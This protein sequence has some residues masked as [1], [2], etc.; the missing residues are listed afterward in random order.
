[1]ILNITLT[2][3]FI[4]SRILIIFELY[5]KFLNITLS[6]KLGLAFKTFINI[7]F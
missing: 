2:D 1:M 3:A 7:I 4:L 5:L 6:R